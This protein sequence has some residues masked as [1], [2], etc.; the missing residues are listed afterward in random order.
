[1]KTNEGTVRSKTGGAT[2][3][4]QCGNNKSN[5]YYQTYGANTLQIN[6]N[7]IGD[8]SFNFIRTK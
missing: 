8:L 1:M 4:I 7:F 6:S 3:P 5:S 2:Y